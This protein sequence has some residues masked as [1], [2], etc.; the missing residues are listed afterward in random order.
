[1]SRTAPE[2]W[3]PPTTKEYTTFLDTDIFSNVHRDNRVP[4]IP[5]Y[6]IAAFCSGRMTYFAHGMLYGDPL[7]PEEVANTGMDQ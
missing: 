7:I 3:A 1:M 4:L 6:A 2:P 5:F